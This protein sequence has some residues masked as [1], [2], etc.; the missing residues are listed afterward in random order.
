MIIKMAI[1]DSN[2]DYLER[3]LNVL[4]G[5]EDLAISVYTE[6]N[7]LEQAITTKHFDI[8]LFDPSVYNG[9]VEVGKSTIAV[10]MLDES[11]GVPEECRN[12]KKV[13][14]YQRISKTYQQLLELYASICGDMSG[15]LGGSRVTKI[16]YYS[17]VGGVG[18][19][20]LALASAT[21]LSLIGYRVFYMSLEDIASEDCYLPQN[22]DRGL[23]E[24]AASL[25]ENINFTMKIQA[26]LQSKNE[27]LFY[28][29]HFDSP[30]DVYEMQGEEIEELIE[31]I[32]KTALFDFIV[33]DTGTSM[34]T[35]MIKLFEA[36]DK[37]VVVEK[38][39]DIS[40]RKLN[41]FM[42]QNHI[43]NEYAHKMCRVVNFDMGKGSR[44]NSTIPLI[45]K[46]NAAH[47]PDSAQL[48]TALANDASISFVTGFVG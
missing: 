17:P 23:S 35:K 18:K 32:E 21:R 16:A 10:M 26:L 24:I 13:K 15:V 36:V 48:I 44:L 20:T 47:N 2:E 25:G 3:L 41:G 11:I 45:G 37:I 31:Q 29:N 33:V 34:N 14:K 22:G 30:N 40:L 19:T 39:D 8:L 43:I 9:Q 28:L 38:S 42:E 27:K 5:Y 6:K 1:A 4:E 7:S 46:V 12:F